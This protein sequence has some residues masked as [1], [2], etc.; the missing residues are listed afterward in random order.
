MQIIHSVCPA[1]R[2]EV[3]VGAEVCGSCGGVISADYQEGVKKG[4]KVLLLISIRLALDFF[5]VRWFYLRRR[6]S[7][8]GLR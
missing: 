7:C 5:P 6:E 8:I 2:G 1:C 3:E 4:N